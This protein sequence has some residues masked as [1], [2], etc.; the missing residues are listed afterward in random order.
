MIDRF[1]PVTAFVWSH[2]ESAGI[3]P[4]RVTVKHDHLVDPGQPRPPGKDF[5]FAA[6]LDPEKGVSLLLD[7]WRASGITERSLVI[8]GDGPQRAT[9]AAAAGSDGVVWH[10]CCPCRRSGR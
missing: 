5:L 8:V 10:G 3:N 7:A 1:L 6:R 4:Q 9:V 2:L